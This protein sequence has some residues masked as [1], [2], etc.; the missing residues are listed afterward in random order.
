LP[1]EQVDQAQMKLGHRVVTFPEDMGEDLGVGEK[2]FGAR[3][4]GRSESFRRSWEAGKKESSIR[5]LS[6]AL[7]TSAATSGLR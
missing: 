3:L 5:E 4:R 7:I 1:S 2:L 6:S